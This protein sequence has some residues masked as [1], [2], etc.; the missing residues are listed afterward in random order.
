MSLNKNASE[1]FQGFS[2]LDRKARLARLIEMGAL[3]ADDVRFLQEGATVKPELAEKFIENVIGYFQMPLGVATNFNIDGNDYVIPMAVE[4]TSIIAALCKTAKWIRNSGDIKTEVNGDSIIGQI[5]IAKVS[6]FDKFKNII[7][8]NTPFLIETAN[9]DVAQAMV[10]RGGGVRGITVRKVERDDGFT[11]AVIHVLADTCDAMGA[12]TIIQ[13]CEYLKDPVERLTGETVTM[14]ILS[15]LNDTKLTRATVTLRNIDRELGEKIE[16]AS[17]FAECD[18]YRAAT[19]NKGVLN[20]VDPV[21]IATGNDWRAVEAGIHAYAARDGQYRSIT[22]W[23]MQGDDLVGVFEAPISVGTVGGVTRLHPTAQM[24]LQM[25]GTTKAN[26]LSRV[27]AAVGLVQNLGALRALITLGFTEGHMKLHITNL[28]LSAGAKEDEIPLLK[29]RLE[30]VLAF[31]KRITRTNAV[32][33]LKE[34]RGQ[35]SSTKE[36]TAV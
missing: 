3:T 25:L 23:R 19:N 11:M 13:I 33:L 14:C 4:E 9:E 34:I 26:D 27:V 12:N 24:S 8:L 36:G 5:Q 18:P 7:E 20:G 16:E 17:I 1:L 28:T 29:K 10:Q 30:E 32:E 2:K 31:H 22:R 6:D 21:L 15:N 35:M